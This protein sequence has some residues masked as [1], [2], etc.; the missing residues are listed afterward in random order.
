MLDSFF[1]IKIYFSHPLKKLEYSKI[2]IIN[3]SS[4]LYANILEHI[5]HIHD[6]INY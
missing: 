5:V 1:L 2:G 4:E 6:R 3:Y